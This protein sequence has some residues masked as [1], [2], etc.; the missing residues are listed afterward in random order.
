[1]SPDGSDRQAS[2][3]PAALAP[4]LFLVSWLA[5]T[6]TQ[7]AALRAGL[8]LRP[9]LFLAELTLAIPGVLA[10]A[11]LGRSPRAALGLLGTEPRFALL[12]VWSGAAFWVASLGLLELQYA[13]WAPPPG[14]LE[15]FRLLHRAL[16]PAGPLDVL[17]SIAAIAVAPAVC[18]EILFRGVILPSFLRPLGAT[19]AILLSATLFGSIHL[20]VIPGLSSAGPALT[21]Y[22]VPFALAVGVGLGLL[23]V[24]TG[25][26]W[27][28][29]LAHATLNTITF[30]VAPWVDDPGLGLPA[31]E[32]WKGAGLLALGLAGFLFAL[33][34]LRGSKGSLSF[35]DT[36][37]S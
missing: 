9:I 36:L 27:P 30:A 5:M 22:R 21:F 32:P 33:L 18:E 17:V 26:L 2:P 7:A 10:L 31:P 37:G 15:A 20:D 14:F 12:A 8:G 1:M 28:S 16:K 13:V 4:L 3:L 11:L 34:R 23:R 35:P 29:L 6:L 24:R 19:G 25:S